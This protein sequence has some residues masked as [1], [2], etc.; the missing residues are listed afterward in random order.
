[1]SG[2][3]YVQNELLLH[4]GEFKVNFKKVNSFQFSL[5]TNVEALIFIC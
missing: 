3:K 4:K 1:M 2:M 5:L